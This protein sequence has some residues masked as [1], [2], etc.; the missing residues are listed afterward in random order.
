MS[1]HRD[2][3]STT[4]VQTRKRGAVLHT[5][6]SGDG[7]ASSLVRMLSRPGDRPLGNTGRRYGSGYHAVT[8]GAGGYVSIADAQAGPYHAPPVNKTMWA[9]CLPGRAAQTRTEWLDALSLNHIR[10]AAKFLV[11]KSQ[12]DGFPLVRL[13]VSELLAG[14]RGY[15]DHGDIAN[16]W[17]QTSHWDVG[18]GFPWDVLAAEI[19]A[20]IPKPPPTQPDPI[21][22][23]E[24][25]LHVIV[26]IRGAD[27]LP[28]DN[29]RFAWDGISIRWIPSQEEFTRL[30]GPIE[31]NRFKLFD[32]HPS[33]SRLDAPY[34]MP[35][36]EIRSYIGGERIQ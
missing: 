30:Y 4:G 29:R 14:D 18:P 22:D 36:S 25:P 34:L 6:E 15:C 2:R 1:L 32:L 12:I 7:S 24:V 31:V 35:L 28:A 23:L 17:G 5:S 33:Y 19:D 11:E 10:G 20:L 16:A 9:I 21:P 13:T 3:Y 8:D 26:A 27:G